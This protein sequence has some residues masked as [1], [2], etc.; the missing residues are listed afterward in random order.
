MYIINPIVIVITLLVIVFCFISIIIANNFQ[1]KQKKKYNE[2]LNIINNRKDSTFQVKDSLTKDEINEIDSSVD[3]DSLMTNL[4]D[5]FINL[6]NKLKSF[7]DN[8]DNI[9]TGYIKD[10]YKTRI[11]DF[12]EKGFSEVTD[13]IDL[14]DYSITE[15]SKD[16][17]KFRIT[18][19]CLYYKIMNDKIVSGSNLEKIEQIL[20]LT[21]ENVDNKWLISSFEKIFEKKS[22]D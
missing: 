14:I 12:K 16:K 17:L 8:F 11:E 22:S 2:C 7:D 10:F 9:L 3:V 18:I 1:K 13:S 6:E 21:Y 19:N 15:F 20:L 4:Y 5:T